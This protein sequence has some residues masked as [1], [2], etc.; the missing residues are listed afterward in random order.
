MRTKTSPKWF[1]ATALTFPQNEEGLIVRKSHTY[2]F[3]AKSFAEAE[4][5]I[6]DQVCLFPSVQEPEVTKIAIAPYREVFLVDEN[7]DKGEIFCKAKV[8]FI[9]YDEKTA[10]E[11]RQ[12]IYYLV[13]CND[14]NT[15]RQNIDKVLS[16]SMIDYRIVSISETQVIDVVLDVQDN[17]E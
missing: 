6:A 1:E 11:R 13:Q 17:D 15:A 10:R 12:T 4:E 3:D 8:V 2:V 5:R 9:T 14:I 16:S 7:C